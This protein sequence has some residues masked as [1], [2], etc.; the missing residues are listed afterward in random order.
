MSGEE[1]KKYLKWAVT[2]ED[3]LPQI[4]LVCNLLFDSCSFLENFNWYKLWLLE[5][6]LTFFKPLLRL[7]AQFKVLGSYR[8]SLK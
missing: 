7:G 2:H 6:Y 1:L 4:L 3:P 8:S 5:E